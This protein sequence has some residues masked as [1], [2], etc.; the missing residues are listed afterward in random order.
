M[1]ALSAGSTDVLV[2]VKAL[3]ELVDTRSGGL[4]ANVKQNADVRLQERAE[5]IE[6]PTMRVEL[7]LVL[8]LQ[9]EED[10]QGARAGRNLAGGRDDHVRGVFEN[11]SSNIFA[12]N[13]I[14]GNAFLITSH[15]ISEKK[16]WGERLME[17]VIRDR[18]CS[19]YHGQDL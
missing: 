2:L 13:R 4:R 8:L 16:R 9:A 18:D 7:L 10:L 12:R 1:D 5:S 3:P 17:V 6:E 19:N 11:M 14:L 15:L